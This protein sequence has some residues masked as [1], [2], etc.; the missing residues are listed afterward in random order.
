MRPPPEAAAERA[1][2]P[3]ERRADRT[4]RDA[5]GDATAAMKQRGRDIRD[6]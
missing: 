1:E 4:E 3:E 5:A 6:V 2:A